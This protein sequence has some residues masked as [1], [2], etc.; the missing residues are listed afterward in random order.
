M[1]CEPSTQHCNFLSKPPQRLL[2]YF[3]ESVIEA[4]DIVQFIFEKPASF[5]FLF[6]QLYIQYMVISFG[7]FS[8]FLVV[9]D[10]LSF[11]IGMEIALSCL[12]VFGFHQNKKNLQ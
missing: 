8:L 12:T 10:C 1:K 2:E 9:E 4:L 6:F 3:E 5:S 7:S 11:M